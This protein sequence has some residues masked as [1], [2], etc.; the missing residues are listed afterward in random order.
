MENETKC[1]ICGRSSNE[2]HIQLYY[3]TLLCDKHKKQMIEYGKI[4]DPT[5]RTT[6]DKNEI[7]L[8]NDYAE[9][10]I[11]NKRNEYICS[12]LI[13]KEDVEFVT[14]YKWN[15]SYQ[16]RRYTYPN[17]RINGKTT[18]LHKYLLQYNGDL[19]VDHI[20]R[21]IFDNR[22]KN[23]RIVTAETNSQNRTL[24]KNYI[25]KYINDTWRVEITRS[26]KRHFV[27]AIKTMEEAIKI[28]DKML[29]EIDG[30]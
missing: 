14:K 2:K 29:T 5:S 25:H 21:N 6:R 18:K 19:L 13:D 24:K 15:V 7:I 1:A 3:G 23:L 11:R 8:H 30:I 9:M 28:R 17:A 16:T 27:N 4:T 10:V 22:R 12:V 26:G 20:N